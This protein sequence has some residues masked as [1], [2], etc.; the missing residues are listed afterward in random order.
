MSRIKTTAKATIPISILCAITKVSKDANGL[1]PPEAWV[2]VVVGL[3]IRLDKLVTEVLVA[4]VGTTYEAVGV[5]EVAES[6]PEKIIK[7]FV[8]PLIGQNSELGRR[9]WACDC[10]RAN[11]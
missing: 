8:D 4:P 11:E 6:H 5:E 1:L 10:Y 3:D 9:W 2:V 7:V